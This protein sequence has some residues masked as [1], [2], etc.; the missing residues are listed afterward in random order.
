MHRDRR[1]RATLIWLRR[2]NAFQQ[3]ARPQSLLWLT[4]YTFT[5]CVFPRIHAHLPHSG[6]PMRTRHLF[7]F[8]PIDSGILYT[9]SESLFRCNH[10][11]QTHISH[12]HLMK[13][14]HWFMPLNTFLIV[15]FVYCRCCCTISLVLTVCIWLSI[16]I[17]PP[18]KSRLDQIYVRIREV[19]QQRKKW[20]KHWCTPGMYWTDGCL[21]AMHRMWCGKK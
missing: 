13:L 20:D 8:S 16:L 7:N 1:V 9:Y 19:R 18:I 12:I 2:Q 21:L 14:I 3:I 15:L 11:I 5:M 6:V 10:F 17:R 4:L